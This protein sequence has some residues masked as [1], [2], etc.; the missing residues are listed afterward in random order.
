VFIGP[1]E[2]HSNELPWRESC[3]DL[4]TIGQDGA[5]E[6]DLAHLEYELRRHADRTVKIGSFLAASN[7]TGIASDVD[8]ISV[9][10]H[11]HG[12]L[13]CWDYAAAGPY[14]PIDMN[15]A[16][17]VP[18]GHLAY[19]DA[20]FVSPHKFIGGPGTPGVLVA[21]GSL[22]RN[23]V[24]SVPGGGTIVWV[25]PSGHAYHPDPTTREEGG[26]PGIV[27]SI[28]AGLVFALKEQVGTDEIRSR[29]HDLARRALA[30]WRA[31]PNLEILGSTK[32]E[33]LPII[34]F[35]VRHAGRL[36]H[37]NF[38]VALLNDLFGIRARSGCFCAGPY[39]HR[40]YPIDEAWSARMQA[41]AAKGEMGAMLSFTRLSFNYFMSETVRDY[42]VD[43]IHLV[44]EGGWKLMPLYRFDPSTGL[45]RHLGAGA[46][47]AHI[48]LRDALASTPA[49]PATAP[50]SIL[51]DQLE[52]AREVIAAVETHPP[53]D[54]SPDPVPS[55]EF[56][57]IRWF[58]LPGEG[59]T[60]LTRSTR[61]E[62]TP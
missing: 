56:E 24:P 62:L 9:R 61:T 60:Q 44:A 43:A 18:D 48:S 40:L 2:H 1:Y 42:I 20:V 5:G 23:Q 58:P 34:S 4:V 22:F 29:E 55:A 45:W 8:R 28:R 59:L 53:T 39:I 54:R 25:S 21:K 57:R 35:G 41:E 12:A 16:P 19:K 11:R 49:P 15:A 32:L 10:L 3:A 47:D 52:A 33:R 17:P 30:S 38:V 6:I 37:A 50:E 26:T 36:L 13:A 31:N 46:H 14:L 27:E 7:V 51:V